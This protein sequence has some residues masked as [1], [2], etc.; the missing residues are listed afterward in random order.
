MSNQFYVTR[1][2]LWQDNNRIID[3]Y[4]EFPMIPWN[5]LNV[6][7]LSLNFYK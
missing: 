6:I 1:D 3:I 2:L 7:Q 4:G 5:I